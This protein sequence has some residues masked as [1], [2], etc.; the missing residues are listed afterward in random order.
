M[1]A[2]Y[3]VILSIALWPLTTAFAGPIYCSKHPGFIQPGMTTEQVIAACGK[4]IAKMPEDKPVLQRVPVTQ[5]I[6]KTI[7]RGNV[8]P[9]LNAA[10]YTQWSTPSGDSVALQVDIIN[11][12]VSAVTLG[13]DSSNAMSLCGGASIQIG[14][15][16]KQVY[17]ACGSPDMVSNTFINQVIPHAAKPEVWMYQLDPNSPPASLTFVNGELQSIN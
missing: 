10:F 8:Y 13:G 15:N 14:T 2:V 3:C 4:P 12:K 16:V 1:K 11:D 9:G 5:V 6:Y 7:N 17:T